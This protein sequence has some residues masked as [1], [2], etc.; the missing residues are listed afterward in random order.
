MDSDVVMSL[1]TVIAQIDTVGSRVRTLARADQELRIGF[2]LSDDL[3]TV[4]HNAIFQPSH[5]WGRGALKIQ[6]SN[7]CVRLHYSLHAL[8]QF[9]TFRLIDVAMLRRVHAWIKIP[10]C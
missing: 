2:P 8:N 4:C 6:E 1:P 3:A 7:R 9:L 5:F 10:F